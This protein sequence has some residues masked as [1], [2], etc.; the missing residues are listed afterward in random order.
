[1]AAD[2][3]E[4]VVLLGLFSLELHGEFPLLT[5]QK[6]HIWRLSRLQLLP[7][8]IPLLSANRV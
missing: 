5:L 1:M 7:L 3:H 4:E 6:L 8:C 2:L